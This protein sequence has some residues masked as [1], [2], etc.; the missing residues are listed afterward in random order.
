MD[1]NFLSGCIVIIPVEYAIAQLTNTSTGSGSRTDTLLYPI[2]SSSIS[3]SAI[4]TH[5]T[6]TLYMHNAA[7]YAF[8]VSCSLVI[9]YNVSIIY[10]ANLN[11][12]T[13]S[14]ISYVSN[15][16]IVINS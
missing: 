11:S 12:S 14:N 6:N 7:N 5:I 4:L 2:T 15:I 8:Y 16:K 1:S 13:I 10:D 9:D 3:T